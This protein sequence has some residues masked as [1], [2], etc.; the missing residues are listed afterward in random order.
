VEKLRTPFFI[1]AMVAM[2]LAVGLETGAS[3]L[4][5]LGGAAT[6]LATLGGPAGIDAPALTPQ[7]PSG[8]AIPYLALIDA[9]LLGTMALMGASLVLSRRWASRLQG[10]VTLVSAIILI[11]TAIVLVIV[12]ITQLILMVALLL[13]FPFGTIVYLILWGSFPRGDAAVV[14]SV[15]MFLKI[16]AAGCLV[17]AQPRFLQNKGLVALI[18][19]SIAA[20]IVASFLHGMVP[21][22][23]VSIT[24]AIAAI[25]FAIVGIVWAII[26]GAGSIPAIVRAASATAKPPVP[27]VPAVAAA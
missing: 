5:G 12:A 3:L 17:V 4:L 7:V 16:V 25:I 21:G 24:D 20:T 8:R 15:L 11:I 23:L 2:G 22:I 14:L 6:D 10:V 1:I 13:A 18:I 9:I 27:A 26:L 19:T